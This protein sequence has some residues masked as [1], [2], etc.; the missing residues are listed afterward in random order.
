MNDV[1]NAALAYHAR[2]WCAIPIRPRSKKPVDDR[3]QNI[4]LTADEMPAHFNDGQNVGVH[5]GAPSD[6]LVDVDLDC[7]EAVS[8]AERFLPSSKAVFGR[9][10]R[11]R[12]HHMYVATP[13]P[14]YAKYAD[15]DQ[16]D[17]VTL[18]ELR[19]DGHQTVLPP[20]THES[21]EAITWDEEG[22][23]ARV[24]G[25]LLTAAVAKVAAAALLARHWR[26][27]VRN[28][29]AL[30]LAGGLLAA[31]WAI[32]DVERF[33]LAVADAAHDEEASARASLDPT[34]TTTAAKTTAERIEKGENV[35]GWPRLAELLTSAK[36]VSAVRKWLGI[37]AAKDK[38]TSQATA[39]V[40]LAEDTELFVTPE[41][42]AYATL[43]VEGHRE[44]H[45]LRSNAYK[46][47]LAQR[48]Y[49][50]HGKVP[51]SQ[52]IH[53][54]LL[55]LEGDAQRTT[56]VV[57]TRVAG[58]GD[59]IYID[60]ANEKWEAIEIT[61]HGWR[62]IS[63][64]PVKFRR[65]RGTAP[66]P[67]PITGGSLNELP[68]FVNVS[69]EH[70]PL[71]V[72]FTICALNPRG[73]Y[74][75]LV[76][77]GEQGSAKTSAGRVLKALVDPSTSPVRS[78]PRDPG[79]VMISA[80]HTHCLLYDNLSWT[81]DW[82]SDVFCRLSTGGGFTKRELYSDEDEI[83]LD[84]KR[85]LILNGIS[86]VATR[87]DLLDRSF[88]IELP[89]IPE[90]RRRP[91][92]ELWAAF[93]QARPRIL[94]ALYDA[95]AC[96]LCNINSVKLDQLPRMADAAMWVV[97]AEPSLPWDAGT[98]V[99]ALKSN[100]DTAHDVALEA[101]PVVT[102]LLGIAKDGPFEGTA[103][104]LLDR[105]NLRASVTAQR[106]KRWPKDGTRL[107]GIVR[108]LAPALRANGLA[109]EFDDGAGARRTR[110]IIRFPAIGE[111]A[112]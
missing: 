49:A 68:A 25:A 87:S 41:Q 56:R 88:L 58:N 31:G 8:V 100:R 13:V 27:G 44:T 89:T 98:F 106:S 86:D 94:G 37:V 42:V 45:R 71:L 65:E 83:I 10:T 96:A 2:D 99:K 17:K 69:E 32:E 26:K 74:P 108:R 77:R 50:E 90:D 22:E 62:V 14:K 3:W 97:A 82:L 101:E 57:Y 72:G 103:T 23:P 85:P 7:P 109:I 112:F 80:T 20:S 1:L 54:A 76:M 19:Q 95:V 53:D 60:L 63:D 75:V 35:T 24:D 9:T 51:G 55:T 91:E 48:Y 18:V 11:R 93:E 92:S 6:G 46:R 81:P 64:A 78:V 30:A 21:G 79:D 29:L 105:L 73:P 102:A 15:P 34:I 43:E 16:P 107:S 36:V 40:Q 52:A 59:A 67:Y 111:A 33:I 4:R 47:W 28:D 39:L 61:P 84:A 5:L 66:L 12:S 70:V 104:E 110:R 38:K